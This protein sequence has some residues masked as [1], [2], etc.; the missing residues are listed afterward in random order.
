MLEGK[1]DKTLIWKKT[2]SDY[3]KG[4]TFDQ[5]QFE[6]GQRPGKRALLRILARYNAKIAKNLHS[7]LQFS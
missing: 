5:F 7:G 1:I 4:I 3:K 2:Q 6:Q